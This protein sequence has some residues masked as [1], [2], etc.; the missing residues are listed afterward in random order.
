M[1]SFYRR[2]KQHNV[3]FNMIL[4]HGNTVGVYIFDPEGNRIETYWNTGLKA[5]QPYGEV[6]DLEQPPKE[7]LQHIEQHAAQ[8]GETGFLDLARLGPR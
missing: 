1:L 7:I 8:Y 5:K 4:S 3:K 6:L 2:F